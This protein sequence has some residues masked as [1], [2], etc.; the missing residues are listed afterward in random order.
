MLELDFIDRLELA[1]I[2]WDS[3]SPPPDD[4]YETEEDFVAELD[5]RAAEHEADP[6]KS[7]SVREVIEELKRERP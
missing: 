2:L 3:V 7:R 4:R 6:S 1:R 5:R